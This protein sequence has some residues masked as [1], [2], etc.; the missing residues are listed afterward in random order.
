MFS[1]LPFTGSK[2]DR[3]TYFEGVR[4]YGSTVGALKDGAAFTLPGVGIFVN[5]RDLYDVDLLS[6]EFGH[7]LQAR[8]WGN[9]FFYGTIVPIS[10][11][12]ANEANNDRT[13][14]HMQTWT[15]WT[16]N[17]FSYH[18]FGAPSNWDFKNYPIE[19]TP[20]TRWGVYPPVNPYGVQIPKR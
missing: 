7:V 1:D 12:S 16:A 13:F 6:H 14:D 11:Q 20:S 10:V 5:P 18:Y 3:S 17:W 4:V 15:E 9:Q 2:A 19:P 8:I